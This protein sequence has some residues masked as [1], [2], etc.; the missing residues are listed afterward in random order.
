MV[1]PFKKR[2]KTSWLDA[3]AAK[4]YDPTA[5]AARK[6]AAEKAAAAATPVEPKLDLEVKSVTPVAEGVIAIT[7][8][9]PHGDELPAWTP[10]SHLEI[11][12]PNGLIRQYSLCGDPA[13][14]M[15]YRVSVLREEEGRG[16]SKELHD[17]TRLVGKMLT[18]TQPRNHFE[19]TP[20][21]K[22]LFIAGGIGVTPI[23][24]M[25]AA[26]PEDAEWTLLYGGRTRASMAFV[27]ELVEIGGDRI[28]IAP[29]DTDGILDLK[30]ALE[31]ID[32]DTAVYC[33]GPS[34]LIAAVEQCVE[35]YAPESKLYFER[36]TASEENAAARAEAAKGDKPFELELARTGVTMTVGA[37]E[38]TLDAV[39]KHVPGFDYSC[40]EGHCGSC[41]TKVLSGE[42]DH[43]D[44]G[45]LTEAE[46]AANTEMYVCV[47]RAKG[48]KLVLDV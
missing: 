38:R 27:D 32:A 10:G 36:F 40:E 5:D 2:A 15:E 28:K 17:D 24:A 31:A 48:D 12:T 43:R 21:K 6:L 30:T 13:N 42:V 4:A 20:S 14:R 8:I 3:P 37:D 7:F 11:H 35:K 1:F 34:A 19:L 16:G 26:V 41:W 44:D 23:R 33:C 45:L 18:A 25:V 47:S 22:Y 39:I 46:R 9:D 29:Q